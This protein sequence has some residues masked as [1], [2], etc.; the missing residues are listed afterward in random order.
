MLK[1]LKGVEDICR[2]YVH[3]GV[4]ENISEILN[5]LIYSNG[6]DGDGM[7]CS[8]D[9]NIL[10]DK[11]TEVR[12]EKHKYQIIRVFNEP[13]RKKIK[14]KVSKVD[15]IIEYFR[16]SPSYEYT[17][18]TGSWVF[19]HTRISS[20]DGISIE[21]THPYIYKNNQRYLLMQNGHEQLITSNKADYKAI[22]EL[23]NKIK[24][25]DV[26]IEFLTKFTSSNFLVVDTL[27]E[28]FYIISN[29]KFDPLHLIRQSED[30]FI[31]SS[32]DLFLVDAEFIKFKGYLEGK[33]YPD[34]LLITAGDIEKVEDILIKHK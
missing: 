17:W 19:Y 4:R 3:S 23:I 15:S 11:E 10:V 30:N 20:T 5:A 34:R 18:A 14:I 12:K 1:Q 26:L 27:K 7:I 8:D 2:L 21:N 31:V 13:Y 28:K 33:I 16:E 6:G 25:K 32:E 9:F 22:T 24:S 29:K